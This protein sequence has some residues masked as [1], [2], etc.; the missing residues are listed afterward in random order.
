[1]GTI[2]GIG[3]K[4]VQRLF[5]ECKSDTAPTSPAGGRSTPVH[6]MGY[7]PGCDSRE[8]TAVHGLDYNV[9]EIKPAAVESSQ[10]KWPN[11]SDHSGRQKVYG[12]ERRR[13]G[14]SYRWQ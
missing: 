3:L 8:S 7:D 9:E 10:S 14:K 2:P 13:P 1:M 5:G 11:Y 12:A 4:D 6:T